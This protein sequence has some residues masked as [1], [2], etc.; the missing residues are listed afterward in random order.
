[1]DY[2]FFF[3]AEL[4]IPLQTDSVFAIDQDQQDEEEVAR[5]SRRRF[6]LIC[7]DGRE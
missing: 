4:L 5:S 7:M 6:T 1:M 3:V 2:T